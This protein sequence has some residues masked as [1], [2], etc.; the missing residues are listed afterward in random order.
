M[1]V[2]AANST[3]SAGV[4]FPGTSDFPV[5]TCCGAHV[6]LTTWRHREWHLGGALP[7]VATTTIKHSGAR[8]GCYSDEVRYHQ[9]YPADQ[10]SRLR[11]VRT[12]L[13]SART[14]GW[15]R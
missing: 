1:T 15:K 12:L 3:F 9:R 6:P 4:R 13:S 2:Q 14:K 8:A 7:G 5:L 10:G 11:H